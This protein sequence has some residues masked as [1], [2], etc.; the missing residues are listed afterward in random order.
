MKFEI[1][2]TRTGGIVVEAET[3]EEA[4]DKVEEMSIAELEE[5]AQLSSWDTSDFR[6]LNED[7]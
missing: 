6:I 7:S 2:I 3:A 1:T 5:H 4:I